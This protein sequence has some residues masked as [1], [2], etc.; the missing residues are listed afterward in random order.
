MIVAIVGA[1]CTTACGTLDTR[2]ARDPL[3]AHTLVGMNLVDLVDVLGK[4]DAT[5]Q[6]GPDTAIAEW[7]HVD[8]AAGLEL[9]VALLGSLKLGGA[10]GCTAVFTVLRDGTI[11]DVAFPRAYSEGLFAPPYSACEPLIGEAL[12]H[13]GSTQLPARYDAFKW[14][15]NTPK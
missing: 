4:P 2:R 6:T 13:P 10:G 9:T 15:F 8:T 14:L 12:R 3:G 5:L 7:T 11:A 1:I